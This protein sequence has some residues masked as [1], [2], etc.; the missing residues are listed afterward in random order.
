MNQAEYGLVQD[1][2]CK[3]DSSSSYAVINDI[4]TL[5]CNSCSVIRQFVT[6][7]KEEYYE[8]YRNGYYE[9][10]YTRT[11]QDELIAAVKRVTA[12]GDFLKGKILDIGCG[13]GGFVDY[14]REKNFDCWGQE[15]TDN[16]REVSTYRGELE[17]INFPTDYFQTVTIHDV[18]EHIIDPVSFMK[19]VFRLTSQEGY[20]I[21]DV[22]NFFSAEGKKH[23]RKTQHL[24]MFTYSQL[25]DLLKRIGFDIIKMTEPIPGKMVFYLQKPKQERTKI[26][27]PPGIGDIYWVLTKL[28]S[29]LEINN[30]SLPDIYIQEQGVKNRGLGYLEKFPFLYAKDYIAFPNNARPPEFAEAYKRDE[31]T[32]FTNVLGCDYFL[33][34]N[35]PMRF[36]KSLYNIHPEY[37][38][39]YY[40]RMFVDKEEEIYGRESLEKYGDYII[41][42]FSNHKMYEH[43]LREFDAN[44]IAKSF[45]S[46]NHTTGYKVI[47]VGSPWDLD[48]PAAEI[49][50]LAP[51]ICIN[52]VNQ[53]SLTQLFGLFKFSQGVIG[54][55]SGITIMSVALKVRTVVIWNKYFRR[56]FWRNACAI[57]AWNHW[58]KALDSNE[59]EP[60]TLVDTFLRVDEW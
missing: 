8:Y 18:L 33:A 22:P 11:Y 39:D 37:E 52:L 58:Y 27:L 42:Y 26:L 21:V 38:V 15:I 35:G 24:W 48:G 9:G 25:A 19:E 1:C 10:D 29:F 47:L 40:P 50:R 7:T 16:S 53:T 57:D 5:I 34:F 6:L 12:Y 55:P 3:E 32:I 49:K 4:S 28:E 23:W 2:V 41:G 36:D 17:S 45:I 20:V 14:L 31:E 46:L 51:D 30:I 54:F 43:W 44:K 56:P 13:L 60:Q 59:L